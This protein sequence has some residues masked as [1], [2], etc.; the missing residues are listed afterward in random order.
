MNRG[1]ERSSPRLSKPIH[2]LVD[3]PVKVDVRLLPPDAVPELFSRDD[4][5]GRGD[6]R[7]E[8][9]KRLLLNAERTPTPP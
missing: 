5:A 1:R 6:Q 8:D 2:R 9:P 4:I 3:S 7:G